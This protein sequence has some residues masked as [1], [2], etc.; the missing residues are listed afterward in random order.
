MNPSF[1][2]Q[3]CFNNNNMNLP[4]I[5]LFNSVSVGKHVPNTHMLNDDHRVGIS[6]SEW[7][8]IKWEKKVLIPIYHD[9]L[10][11][12]MHKIASNCG[13]NA[14]SFLKGN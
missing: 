10:K 1:S 12:V 2:L 3:N 9:K 13:L 8:K 11:Y 5:S 6:K 4:E 14:T 7:E